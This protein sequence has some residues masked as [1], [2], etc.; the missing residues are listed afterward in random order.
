M[1]QLHLTKCELEVMDV[2]W[3]K[4]RVTVQDVLDS[5]TRPLAYTTVMTTLNILD[6]K[7]KVVR[8]AKHGRAFVYEATVSRADVCR[9]MVNELTQSLFNGSVKSLML[10]LIEPGVMPAEEIAELKSALR[11]LE[12]NQ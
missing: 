10:T 6:E 8:R 12:E 9:G 7:R 3:T 1:A 11:S 4:G 2:V 5:L